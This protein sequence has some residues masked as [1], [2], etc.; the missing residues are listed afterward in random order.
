[1][2]K[3]KAL[4]TQMIIGSILMLGNIIMI[5]RPKVENSNIMIEGQHRM[6]IND[7]RQKIHISQMTDVVL[8]TMIDDQLMTVGIV[9]SKRGV[10]SPRED[11]RLN[12]DHNMKR[13]ILIIPKN[14]INASVAMSMMNGHQST[15]F[16]IQSLK[17]F[18]KFDHPVR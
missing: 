4:A 3:M 8:R 7:I 10:P 17:S 2:T 16:M 5:V 9:I 15:Q 11:R 12:V 18:Q 13:T 6:T 1:M 14:K